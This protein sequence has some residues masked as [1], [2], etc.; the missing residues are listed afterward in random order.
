MTDEIYDV[1]GIG[2]GPANIALAAAAQEEKPSLR[3]RFLEAR[4]EVEWQPG[5]LL[6]GADIQN[7]P[8]RD[9]ATLRDPRSHFTFMNYLHVQ[10][11]LVAFL[12][13][14][15]HFPLRKDYAGYIRWAAE[16][17]ADLVDYGQRVVGL[18]T[19]TDP[20]PHY[21]TTTEAGKT[22]R[23]R[24]LVVGTGRTPYVPEVFAPLL[25]PEVFHSTDYR[26]RLADRR[27][28]GELGAVAVVGASQ[29]AAEI[30]LD[31]HTTLPHTRVVNIMRSFGPRLKDTS[32]FSEEAFFPEFTDYYFNASPTGKADLDSQLR[33]TN[34]SS[35][36]G[37]VIE[38]LYLRRYEE[39]LDGTSRL[40]FL[41]NY[42]VVSARTRTG[43]VEL[44][45]RER[46]TGARD[47]VTVDAVIVA[48]GFRDLGPPPRG[49]L[50]PPLLEGLADVLAADES[51]ALAV[52]REYFVPPASPECDL[53]PLFLNGLCE[54][55]HGLGDAGSFS[56]L[57]LRAQTILAGISKRLDSFD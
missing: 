19:A 15:A 42:D 24:A 9:L 34:Y 20:V 51:G 10:G 39:E 25:G 18:T 48:T 28:R 50:V 7:N 12:N 17:L 54:S 14:P 13:I 8:L 49:E 44:S 5:M 33:G 30:V 2:F 36:D 23:G 47:T 6:S 53:G 4:A 29:S 1:L 56:L 3:C 16:Q 52:E 35:V 55:S 45:L 38:A 57:S 41:R 46:Q 21:V 31:L 26:R 37:D 40:T 27:A 22:C 11:R 43:Q 32:P